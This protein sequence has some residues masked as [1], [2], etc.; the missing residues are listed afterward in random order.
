MTGNS[1]SLGGCHQNAFSGGCKKCVQHAEGGGVG[2][3]KMHSKW[4][5]QNAFKGSKCNKG[6]ST[7]CVQKGGGKCVQRGKQKCVLRGGVNIHD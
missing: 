4:G 5:Q 2:G 3:A 7:K 6:V 1:F